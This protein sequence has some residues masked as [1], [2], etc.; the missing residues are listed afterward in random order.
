MT[1]PR[2]TRMAAA[3]AA[4]SAAL[5]VGMT[6][7]AIAFENLDCTDFSHQQD[8]HAD[9]VAC[10]SAP[11]RV[12]DADAA[13]TDARGPVGATPATTPPLVAAEVGRGC[14]GGTGV[15]AAGNRPGYPERLGAGPGAPGCAEAAGSPGRRVAAVPAGGVA[16]GGV[17]AS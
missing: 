2:R 10:G 13:G 6:G 12:P 11:R 3:A 14:R 5:V 15:P 9:G 17:P 1:V 8:G 7:T 4:A 16:T